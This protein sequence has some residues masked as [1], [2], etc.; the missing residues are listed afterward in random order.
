MLIINDLKSVKNISVN[1]TQSIIAISNENFKKISN[2]LYKFLSNI[3]YNEF[4]NSIS[5]N[6]ITSNSIK[7]NSRIEMI[8]N[9]S[10]MFSV[11]NN[12]F[13][14]ARNILSDDFV[15]C[16]V[17]QLTR[18]DSFPST[19]KGGQIVYGRPNSE[20]N[21]DFWG[22]IQDV[23]WLSLTGLGD[24]TIVGGSDTLWSGSVI[25]VVL[26][27]PVPPIRYGRYLVDWTDTA[28][29]AF[30]GYE[31][32]I[33][34]YDFDNLIWNFRKPDDGT[35]ILNES[36]AGNTYIAQVDG[37]NISWTAE[38]GSNNIGPDENLDVVPY[39][40]GR[41]T[42]FDEST[43]VGLVVDRYNIDLKNI[44][45]K[46]VLAYK[47]VLGQSMTQNT[48]QE[49]DELY[50]IKFNVSADSIFVDYISEDP[51]IAISGSD[52]VA[53]LI[54][55][56]L[57]EIPDTNG[58]AYMAVYPNP[59]PS[60]A[61]FGAVIGQR[62][63]NGI[64]PMF[65]ADYRSSLLS[66]STPILPND[67]RCWVYQYNSGILYQEKTDGLTPTKLQLYVYRGQLLSSAL[68]NTL[69]LATADKGYTTTSVI[70]GQNVSSG[71]FLTDTPRKDSN[72]LVF[73]NGVYVSV[74]NGVKTKE[75]YFSNDGGTTAKSFASVNAG[76]VWYV[77]TQTLGYDIQ[78]DYVISFEYLTPSSIS[79]PMGS[80]GTSGIYDT[81]VIA[82]GVT[83]DQGDFVNIF[84]DGGLT[85]IRKS[86]AT[87]A[88]MAHGFVKE[89]GVAND[90]IDV[91]FTGINDSVVIAD[92]V[93]GDR[94][95]IRDNGKVSHI[96]PALSSQYIQNVGYMISDTAMYVEIQDAIEII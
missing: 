43:R 47:H 56:D 20:S 72:I 76:D 35:F 18:Y 50:A 32:Y 80:L 16:H 73:I 74:G 87:L 86:D 67:E 84:I 70:S 89:S 69:K 2:S 65:G 66:N 3:V 30:T 11:N 21:L 45:D 38:L 17:F 91:Y 62:I 42:D 90:M 1:S 14:H 46:S 77:N 36:D 10:E 57:V 13:L 85:K 95:Y 92:P 78:T 40:D 41:Y 22:Y 93:S 23:G 44:Y 37:N 9:N 12:G 51:S 28:T 24:G 94:V 88:R 15:T 64:S 49:Y 48:T 82:S 81:F 25:D 4:E 39:T 58:H 31:G 5:L 71:L 83:L 60:N 61:P 54:N 52:P 27:P 6:S 19:T 59:L 68:T 33:A 53:V 63:I 55:A 29:G 34:T 7:L 79:V 96:A 26:S 75:S 8:I